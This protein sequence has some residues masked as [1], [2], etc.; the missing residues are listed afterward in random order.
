MTI[1][2]LYTIAIIVIVLIS[3]FSV[4]STLGIVRVDSELQQYLKYESDALRLANV[5]SQ[6][7]EDLTDSIRL[8][9]MTGDRKHRDSYFLT[10]DVKGGKKPR[11]N[12][13][14]ISF[15][16]MVENMNLTD[17]E[18]NNILL[19]SE[20]SGNLV[21]LETEV[22]NYIDKWIT[23]HSGSNLARS[24]DFELKLQQ[25]RLFN[26]EYMDEID[27]IMEPVTTFQKLLFERTATQILKAEKTKK[28]MQT[29]FL[30]SLALMIVAVIIS[31]LLTYSIVLKI[32]G[33]EPHIINS[34][35]SEVESGNL[36]IEFDV[37]N[38]KE[39]KDSIYRILE[40]TI[41]RIVAVVSST[42]DV[43]GR[44]DQA[45]EQISTSSAQIST[46]ATEQ[47]ASTEE[48]SSSMEELAGNI[49]QNTDNAQSADGTA[50]KVT[51]D[52]IETQSVVNDA[53]AA[54]KIIAEKISVIEDIS[55]NTNMLALNAAIE[56][57]RAG[58]AGKG[59]A[60]VASEVRK[61]AES[62]QKAAGEI[63]E[64]STTGVEKAEKAGG[65]INRIIP[66]IQK[67]AELV[68][69]ITQASMEQNSGAEQVNSA[70]QQMN[71]VIQQ[72][73][74]ASEEMTSLSMGM[75]SSSTE[76]QEVISFFKLSNSEK[77]YTPKQVPPVSIVNTATA[78]PVASARKAIDA[79]KKD[80]V[81]ESSFSDDSEFES[82]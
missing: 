29:L 51:K 59:F 62:S 82:F 78:S 40:K 38:R 43:S 27:K 17:D 45:T 77:S 69:E 30:S 1:K 41:E 66:E 44:V 19:A 67:T 39:N 31:F 36:S 21:V 9:S 76:L 64:I 55:R 23:D 65:L 72:N 2:R 56:A 26:R 58:E 63:T 70:I 10:L 14:L 28:T 52:A 60:V 47:A 37:L 75:K 13:E 50:R 24:D 32:L 15:D 54:I 20:Y 42:Q 11:N 57:A 12:G 4:F 71:T 73:A 25:V 8:Y 74:A 35:L 34:L 80:M 6:S 79:P 18:E 46:G 16:K 22:M 33:R 5:M 49:S 48:I 3:A 68:Q 7:S 61:L 81:E 53:V